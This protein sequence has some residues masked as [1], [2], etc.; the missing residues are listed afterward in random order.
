MA[1]PE[2]NKFSRCQAYGPV[3][4]EEGK[5]LG[6]AKLKRDLA[7][8]RE[9]QEMYRDEHARPF[10]KKCIELGCQTAGEI[11]AAANQ[12]PKKPKKKPPAS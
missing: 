8:V 5:C 9:G 12:F 2:A 10:A 11:R 3:C 7:L 1:R 4:G 6:K